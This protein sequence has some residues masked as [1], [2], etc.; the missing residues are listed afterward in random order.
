[1]VGKSGG[2]GYFF[3]DAGVVMEKWRYLEIGLMDFGSKTGFGNRIR[4]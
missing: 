4:F 2:F 3:F 1:M